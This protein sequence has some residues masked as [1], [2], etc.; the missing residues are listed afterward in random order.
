M[1]LDVLG[2]VLGSAFLAS[3]ITGLVSLASTYLLVRDQERQRDR[4]SRRYAEKLTREHIAVESNRFANDFILEGL[5][6]TAGDLDALGWWVDVAHR[7]AKRNRA[8][9]SGLRMNQEAAAGLNDLR[10]I[11][12]LMAVEPCPMPGLAQAR[13]VPFPGDFM[14]SVLAF[15]RCAAVAIDW[16]QRYPF[17]SPEKLTEVDRFLS[18]LKTTFGASARYLLTAAIVARQLPFRPYLDWFPAVLGDERLIKIGADLNALVDR[19][20]A[21]APTNEGAQ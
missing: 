18:D 2:P 15:N 5:E 20:L 3:I 10:T 4:E 13:L 16:C 11:R 12:D 21:R 1:T 17:T 7:S 19:Q 9:I 14:Q 6:R 8:A